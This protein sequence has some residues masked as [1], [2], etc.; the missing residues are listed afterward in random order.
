MLYWSIQI[1]VISFILIFLVHYLINFF[2]STLTI[3][4]IKDLV[5]APAKKYENMYSVINST[6][7]PISNKGLS[8][9]PDEEKSTMKNELKDFL[10]KQ[11]APDIN[12]MTD[13]NAT[14][15]IGTTDINSIGDGNTMSSSY[16]M[17]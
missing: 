1:T 17:F 11:M 4:K 8:L 9:I 16:S 2:K 6:S 14:T 3:P 5:D 13:I 7:S 10:K 12:A 15:N